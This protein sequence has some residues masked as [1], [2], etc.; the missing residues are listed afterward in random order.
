[1]GDHPSLWNKGNQVVFINLPQY[2]HTFLYCL[3]IYL[4]FSAIVYA[5]AT[6]SEIILKEHSKE[7]RQE[8]IQVTKNIYVA[9][10]FGASNSA[11]IIG[12]TGLIIVDTSQSVT[13]AQA[14]WKEFR[15]ITNKP[16]KAII[17]THSHRDHISGAKVFA[18]DLAPDIYARDNFANELIGGSKIAPILGKRTRRQFGIG[19]PKQQVINLGIGREMWIDGLGAGYIPATVKVSQ[20]R[21]KVTI[22]GV[23]I[24]MVT[25]PG[26]THDQMYV[27]LPEQRVIFPGDNF[28]KAFPNLY[29]IRGS[30]YRDVNL[31]AI[32]LDKMLAEKPQY[33]VPSHTRPV[34]GE[35]NASKALEDYSK[36][37]RFIYDE[38]I[39]GMNKGLTPNELVEIV[40]L[41]ENLSASPYLQEFYGMVPWA[42]KSIFTGYL[43][44]FDG[45][46]T[47][48][49]PFSDTQLAE[50][51]VKM[52][53]GEQ[54]VLNQLEYAIKVGDSQWGLRL[55]DYLLSMP[56][57]TNKVMKLRVV[58][59][60]QIARQQTNAT[61][62]NYYLS[63]ASELEMSLPQ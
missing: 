62:R 6:P 33:I 29:P 47:N 7:F 41:P 54:K 32:S 19:L 9:V 5:Q 8:V 15:K 23:D 44:W 42:V 49:L 26:E 50:R 38:T 28:Y 58:A 52:A 21:Y 14:I 53:G 59:L 34:I 40:T 36:A 27:W 63:V 12:G 55:S 43:G 45:N 18:Q 57:Q 16:V 39:V 24:E 30:S 10:G 35:L 2:F 25:A 22:A 37:I 4:N 31:W 1:M 17:Y 51:I 48:L 13:A 60:R 11:M 3:F 46:P 61:A 20:G 56:Y